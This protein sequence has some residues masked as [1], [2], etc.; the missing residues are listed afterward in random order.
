MDN[1]QLGSKFILLADNLATGGA[2][3]AEKIAM[4]WNSHGKTCNRTLIVV[5]TGNISIPLGTSNIESYKIKSSNFMFRL[6]KRLWISLS[7][8]DAV[9]INLTNFP[10]PQIFLLSKKRA[11]E[12]LLIHNS[13]L[14]AWPQHRGSKYPFK[15]AIIQALKT[16]FFIFTTFLGRP[17][18]VVTQTAWMQSMTKKR[19]PWLRPRTWAVTLP[20]LTLKDEDDQSIH[21]E[22]EGYWF[23]PSAFYPH[24]N[25]Y[26]LVEIARELK[27]RGSST[28]ILVTIDIKDTKG[29]SFL[30]TLNE[31]GLSGVIKNVG[32]LS[33]HD[34]QACLAKS[35]GLL[36][37]ST[38]ETLGLPLLEAMQ[39]KKPIVA[40]NIPTTKEVLGGYAAYFELESSKSSSVIVDLMESSESWFIPRTLPI[41]RFGNTV[42]DEYVIKPLVSLH[43]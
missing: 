17:M 26:L 20:V 39:L 15:F 24:K 6:V 23:Y 10:L 9:I 4:D 12:I 42:I 43:N 5:H 18:C 37:L 13:F 22:R 28:K 29:V 34:T 35:T 27:L 11:N 31:E 3:L 2:R 8:K 30:E 25:H 14:V 1:G 32:W 41:E 19:T 36:F 40:A 38:F 33:A 7:H 16:V 21:A